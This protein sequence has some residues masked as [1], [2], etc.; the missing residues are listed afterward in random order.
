LGL[1][2]PSDGYDVTFIEGTQGYAY[3]CRAS[4][5]CISRATA[6]CNNNFTVRDISEIDPAQ[7]TDTRD[8]FQK[9]ASDLETFAVTCDAPAPEV[10]IEA[11]T[12]APIEV[13]PLDT[14]TPG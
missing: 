5:T 10:D 13:A 12:V 9:A 4:Q 11:I 14:P 8:F 1:G 6:A 2:S 3:W 7:S